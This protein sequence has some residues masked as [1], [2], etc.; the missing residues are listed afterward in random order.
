MLQLNHA[1]IV[2]PHPC[3]AHLCSLLTACFSC[4]LPGQV[5]SQS[6]SGGCSNGGGPCCSIWQKVERCKYHTTAV[7]SINGATGHCCISLLKLPNNTPQ[8]FC[9][10]PN[11]GSGYLRLP[12]SVQVDLKPACTG[13]GGGSLACTVAFPNGLPKGY[14]FASGYTS[15]KPLIMWADKTFPGFKPCNAGGKFRRMAQ[16]VSNTRPVTLTSKCE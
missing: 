15:K 11:A 2:M 12:A 10:A 8:L 5:I 4:Y 3:T 7:A 13:N 16:A 9:A 6:S 14:T 1:A